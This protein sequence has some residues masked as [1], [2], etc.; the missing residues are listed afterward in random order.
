[1]TANSPATLGKTRIAI[2]AERPG[3]AGTI[4][5]A[6]RQAYVGVPWS[7]HREH[8]MVERL[9]QT[10]AFVPALSLVALAGDE[11][12][13]HVLLTKAHVR[14][15][16]GNAEILALAPLSVVPGHRGRGIGARLVREAH[17]R[18]AILGFRAVVLVGILRFYDRLGYQPL[19]RYPILLPFEASPEI[20][21]IL[22]LVPDGLRGLSGTVE[23][24][25][26]WLDHQADN[27]IA[28]IK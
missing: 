11:I 7:D 5:D 21:R 12:A 27:L 15:P 28:V 23:Y 26:G 16:E 17:R 20:C 19:N 22:P 9:R 14:G 3:E 13:G 8:L 18:A 6:I 24:A 10:A 1:M 4:A 2:R 25:P